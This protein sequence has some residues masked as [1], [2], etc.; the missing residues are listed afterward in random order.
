MAVGLFAFAITSF[1]YV[2]AGNIALLVV[3][4]FLQGVAS[5][6]VQPIAQ[7]YVGDI[8][9]VGEEGKWMGFLNATLFA[10]WGFGP[11]MG[12]VLSE[13]FGI[14]IAFYAMGGLNLIAFFSVALFLPE[15]IQGSR[16]NEQPASWKE[17]VRSRKTQGLF[18][19]QLGV[20]SNRNIVITFVPLFAGL[21]IGLNPSL[22]GTILSVIVIGAALFQ[23]LSGRLA[24]RFNKRLLVILGSLAML[25]SMVLVPSAGS[26]WPLLVILAISTVGDATA[27]PSASAMVV[28]EGRKYGMGVAMAVFNVG[29]GVGMTVGPVVAGVMSD[30]LGIGFAFYTCAAIVFICAAAFTLRTRNTGRSGVQVS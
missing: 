2:L 29:M 25:V 5:C 15:I 24:D 20:A 22:V 17:V 28:D 26:F 6:M 23:V 7:A 10:G 9:P 13:Y 27:L 19:F 12:G 18:S 1:A 30:L 4:R 16:D 14:D 3:I 11:L 8:A 21:Y